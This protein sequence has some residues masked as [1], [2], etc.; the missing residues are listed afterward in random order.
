MSPGS[1]TVT[2]SKNFIFTGAGNIT[3][4]TSVKVLGP[5]TL[6][7]ANTNDYVQGTFIQG[8]G[9]V[10]L[11]TNN[12]LPIAGTVTLGSTGSNGTLDLAGFSQQ[13]GDL[14]IGSGAT[15]ASQTITSST[16]SANLIFSGVSTTFAGT[17]QDTAATSGGSLALTVANGL[18]NLNGSNSYNGGT[19]LAGGTLQIGHPL[20]IQNSI[21]TPAGGAWTSAALARPSAG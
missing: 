13:V 6:T 11:G 2:G 21:V 10:I 17:I 16:G 5:G 15:A 14:A 1:V 4:G 3:N 8:G 9:Q 12:G 20:T 19:T 7:I 18:L